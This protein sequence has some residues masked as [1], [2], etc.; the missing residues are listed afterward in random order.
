MPEVRSR[1]LSCGV[2]RRSPDR[3]FLQTSSPC[4]AR[5]LS[6]QTI[7]DR[8]AVEDRRS[9]RGI[10]A[11]AAAFR[12]LAEGFPKL[13][14]VLPR[15]RSR[16]AGHGMYL[17]T[18]T[19]T[20]A[21]SKPLPDVRREAAAEVLVAGGEEIRHCRDAVARLDGAE[22]AGDVA[23]ELCRLGG[24]GAGPGNRLPRPA[25]RPGRD[26]CRSADRASPPAASRDRDGQRI[27]AP[28]S[29]AP[30]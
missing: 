15:R 17:V 3:N 7:P 2:L 4:S 14:G 5:P 25:L 1:T 12:P 8:T 21:R 24:D 22:H 9:S 27:D 18:G 23:A 10:V 13:P 26:P 30:F 16:P 28:R 20:C 19:R 29:G 6:Q 11:S